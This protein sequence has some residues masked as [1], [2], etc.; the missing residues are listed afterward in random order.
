M[1]QYKSIAL[2]NA[3]VSQDNNVTFVK[4]DHVTCLF[5]SKLRGLCS[6]PLLDKALVGL[7]GEMLD[8]DLHNFVHEA[9]EQYMIYKN[10]YSK[11]GEFSSIKLT[12]VFVTKK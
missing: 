1:K 10:S 6:N 2:E 7:S 5:R 3:G 9:R 8:S 4:L 12:P 11:T